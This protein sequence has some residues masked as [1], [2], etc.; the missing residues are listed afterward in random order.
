M[1]GTGFRSA[2]TIYFPLMYYDASAAHDDVSPGHSRESVQ[3]DTCKACLARVMDGS[4][5]RCLEC[6]MR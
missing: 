1:M 2:K 6:N 3:F 5:A 4:F